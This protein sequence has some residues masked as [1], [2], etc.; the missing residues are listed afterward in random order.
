MFQ[1]NVL[2]FELILKIGSI[3]C[4]YGGRQKNISRAPR[5]TGLPTLYL[6]RYFMYIVAQNKGNDKAMADAIR[7]VPFNDHSNCCEL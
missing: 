7:C 4:A 2:Q 5:W 3:I 1:G 6:Q